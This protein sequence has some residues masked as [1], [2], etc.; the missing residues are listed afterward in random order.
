MQLE[1][2]QKF[3][4]ED[5]V[6]IAARLT[7]AGVVWSDPVRQV[8]T[9]FVH[10]ARDF[11]RTDEAFRLRQVGDKNYFTYKGPKIDTTT[12]T[13]RELEVPLVDGADVAAQYQQLLEALG[14]Q[15]GGIVAKSR[16]SGQLA[17]AGRDIEI[18]WD[19]VDDLGAYLEL[20]IVAPAEQLENARAAILGLAR[21][22][23]LGVAE[24]RSYLELLLAKS[25]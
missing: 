11:R 20:E 24:R 3:A 13:R 25:A 6:A 14:F 2:E 19:D 18:V 23:S 15:I 17:N 21:E 4:I 16:R 12:K 5:Q 7:R 22:L 1:I 10:P 8:D 9:Y